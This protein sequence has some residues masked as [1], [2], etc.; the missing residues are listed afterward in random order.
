MSLWQGK[1][2]NKAL[3]T[4]NAIAPQLPA[5]GFFMSTHAECH[6][7]AGTSSAT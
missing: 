3:I 6:K 4:P 7:I 1:S 2:E 5:L